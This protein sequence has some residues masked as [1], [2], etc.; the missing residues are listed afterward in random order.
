MLYNK[1]FL[2][3]NFE[4]P[5]FTIGPV[6]TGISHPVSGYCWVITSIYVESPTVNNKV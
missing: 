6:S 4:K 2:T 3:A 1:L 5:K